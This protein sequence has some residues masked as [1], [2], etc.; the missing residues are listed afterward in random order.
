MVLSKTR[1]RKIANKIFNF[2]TEQVTRDYQRLKGVTCKNLKQYSPIAEVGNKFIDKHTGMERLN[3][4]GKQGISFYE[5]MENLSV[6]KK[7]K[8][9]KNIL[10]YY[11]D[12]PNI[13]QIK[14]WKYIF[15]LYFSSISLFRPITAMDVYC[16]YNPHTVLD[17]TMGWGGR[18]VAAAALDVPEYIGI[19]LNKELKEPY[20]Q[21]TA[22]L[23]GLTNTKFRLMFRDALSV[24]YS[25]LKYDL[26]LTSPPYYNI[27]I[28]SGTHEREKKEWNEGFY[29]PLLS[30]TWKHLQK[31]GHYC[32]NVPDEVY[33]TVCVPLLG[34]A[35]TLIPMGKTSRTKNE[36]YRE[37]IYVWNK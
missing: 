32:L 35:D 19:D 33:Q 7:S 8:R 23:K 27:E 17:F 24:D 10:N 37:F 5:F 4:K 21:M 12:F 11:K 20:A 28:Y 18:M 9:I 30:I 15:N 31:G 2:S 29:K 6:Y 1:K 25:K 16:K 36:K 34:R 14:K 13:P 3:T 22:D 26:V